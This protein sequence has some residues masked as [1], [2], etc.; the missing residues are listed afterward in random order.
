M[1][2]RF[3]TAVASVAVAVA[4]LLA[5]TAPARAQAPAVPVPL[6]TPAEAADY[7]SFTSAEDIGPYLGRLAAAGEGVTV[8]SLPAPTPIPI[9]RIASRPRPKSGADSAVRV[10]VIAA[11][12]GTERAG[13][14]VGLRLVRDLATGRLAHLR[15]SLEVR[16]V[17]MANPWGVA[18]RRGETA[19]GVDMNGD[20]VRLAA[21]ETRALWAEYGA[22]RPHLVLDLH[23]LGPSEYT[24]QIGVPT[25]PNAPGA[26][27]FARFYLLPFVANELA[28]SDVRFHEYVAGWSDGRTTEGAVVPTDD[29]APDADHASGG[30]WFTPAPL[31]PTSA[32]NAFALAGSVAYF[33]A[34]S[35]SRDILGLEE[36]TERLY[37]GVR[38]LLAA[39]AGLA[40]DLEA[41]HRAAGRL[42]KNAL[43]LRPR[44]VETRPDASLPWLFINPRGQREQG[45]LAPWRSEVVADLELDPPAGWWLAPGQDELAGVLRGHGFELTAGDGGASGNQVPLAYPRCVPEREPG[46]DGPDASDTPDG[47]DAV[48]FL[49]SAPDAPPEGALWVDADQPGGRLLFTLLEPWSLGGWFDRGLDEPDACDAAAIFPVVRVPR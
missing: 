19:D 28:G 48:R 2:G 38:A 20:H 42:P 39:A 3:R 5:G 40:P 37:V 47:A 46:D 11:Q 15:R 7:L 36:R 31:D 49:R 26:A 10:L 23:E 16:I 32:R 35:S 44:Y 25:H 43:A 29:A 9:V 34:V 1:T 18:N 24:V 6:P 27:M 45:R 33:V 13:V 41:A 22:W 21:P 17:P 12:H 14:E 4:V 30:T 8:D